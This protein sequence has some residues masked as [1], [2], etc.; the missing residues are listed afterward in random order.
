MKRGKGNVRACAI[1]DLPARPRCSLALAEGQD[2]HPKGRLSGR[3]KQPDPAAAVATQYVEIA[4]CRC[5]LDSV[6]H[7]S[8]AGQLCWPTV[9]EAHSEKEGKFPI[10]Q[11]RLFFGRFSLFFFMPVSLLAPIGQTG[12]S[13]PELRPALHRRDGSR[14]QAD[15]G[16]GSYTILNLK[17]YH[18][19]VSFPSWRCFI[20]VNVALL[21]LPPF[22]LARAKNPS[23][24]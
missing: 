5:R 6:C 16:A 19:W 17:S 22:S 7:R 10:K 12:G 23:Q 21:R 15:P 8:R 13:N 2:Y 24:I 14:V 11:A 9:R 20:P 3:P 1:R 4:T 18:L